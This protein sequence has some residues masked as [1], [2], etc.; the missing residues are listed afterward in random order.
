M[1]CGVR[2]LR[3]GPQCFALVMGSH[4]LGVVHQDGLGDGDTVHV[5]AELFLERGSGTRA[6]VSVDVFA[7]E[8]QADLQALHC[9]DAPAGVDAGDLEAVALG[10]DH[11]QEDLQDGDSITVGTCV[12]KG[13]EQHGAP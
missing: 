13:R 8:A 1:R 3:I 5:H 11:D 9:L 7:L 12:E 10:I 2:G 4:P 6:E